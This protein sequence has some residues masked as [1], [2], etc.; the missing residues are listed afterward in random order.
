[1][2]DER[3]F[4]LVEFLIAAAIMTAVLG[5]SVM[6]ASQIQQ[7][8]S[9]QLDDSTVE[10]EV[11]FTLDWIAQALRNAGSNPYNIDSLA[12]SCPAGGTFTELAS[13]PNA[14]MADDDIRIHADINPPNGLLG[15]PSGNCLEKNEDITIA[16]DP[17]EMWI[18]R[19]DNSMESA[20]VVMTEPVISGLEFIYLDSNRA[21][22]TNPNQA[23]WV[24]VRVTGQP[25][26][27]SAQLGAGR[28]TTLET[29]VRVRT[30]P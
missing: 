5:G 1:M 11:R 6:L 7:A 3:G 19:H 20:P 26:S 13:D 15:G 25:P 29:D 2:R 30:R 4:T 16:L 28:T 8:Y 27:Y 10:E 14:N 23:A 18:T 21:V 22:T 12:T 24:R 9:T 17:V